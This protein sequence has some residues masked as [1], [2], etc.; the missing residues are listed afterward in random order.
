M[1]EVRVQCTHLFLAPMAWPLCN[2]ALINRQLENILLS[3]VSVVFIVSVLS[4]THCLHSC[5]HCLVS[6]YINPWKIGTD[7]NLNCMLNDFIYR[8]T[9]WGESEGPELKI[10][11]TSGRRLDP[12]AQTL[13]TFS[14]ACFANPL[15]HER[16]YST[17]RCL[18]RSTSVNIYKLRWL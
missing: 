10:K 5:S 3:S 17:K 18:A 6:V 14:L 12:G 15:G 2:S 11:D 4:R 9:F 1:A 13:V 16:S 8:I 7:K